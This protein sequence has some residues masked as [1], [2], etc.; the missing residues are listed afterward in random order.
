MVDEK[1]HVD[2]NASNGT[3]P[4]TKDNTAIEGAIMIVVSCTPGDPT[5]TH[6]VIAAIKPK[7]VG[8][9]NAG[10]S[11]TDEPVTGGSME[12]LHHKKIKNVR[13]SMKAFGG[14]LGG[15]VVVAVSG[16]AAVLPGLDIGGSTC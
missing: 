10:K 2:G 7:E 12:N 16:E 8:V 1:G 15:L 11:N 5:L 14:L 9:A 4:G 6:D 3:F 13:D